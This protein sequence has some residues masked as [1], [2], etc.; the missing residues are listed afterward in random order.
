MGSVFV[1]RTFEHHRW[2]NLG[3]FELCAGLHGGQLAE[4]VPG[5]YGRLGDTLA[6]IAAAESGY[7]WRFD[8]GERLRW[9]IGEPIPPV[10][11]MLGELDRTGRRLAELA[12]AVPDDSVV[13]Y[14]I[15]GEQR[16]W[17]A[18]VILTQAVDHAAEHRAHARTILSVLGIGSP[19]WDVWSY[20]AA[21]SG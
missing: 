7:V 13:A 1:T 21:V 2:A 14:E 18:W 10:Q 3:L 6:H 5:T 8:Q 9:D 16:R 17:P 4:A 20:A 15:E 12:L 11:R 19:E